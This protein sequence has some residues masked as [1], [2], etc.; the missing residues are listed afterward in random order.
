MYPTLAIYIYIYILLIGVQ[1]NGT[2]AAIN[3]NNQSAVQNQPASN[4]GR[5]YVVGYDVVTME[6]RSIDNLRGRFRAILAMG[7]MILLSAVLGIA[8]ALSPNLQADSTRCR[9]MCF[10]GFSF[11]TCVGGLFVALYI[12]GF[13]QQANY[14]AKLYFDCLQPLLDKSIVSRDQMHLDNELNFAGWLIILAS[15]SGLTGAFWGGTL[16]GWR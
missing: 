8:S 11:P 10:I 16:V 4:G 9:L 15:F 6:N 1:T 5:N 2:S 7:F 14:I 13:R 3:M 12:L